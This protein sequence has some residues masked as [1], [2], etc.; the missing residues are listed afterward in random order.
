MSARWAAS[1]VRPFVAAAALGV[2]ALVLAA[3]ACTGGSPAALATAEQYGGMCPPMSKNLV[4]TTPPG[5]ACSA[6]E[7]CAPTCCD[8][9]KQ[10]KTFLAASCAGNACAKPADACADVLAVDTNQST[11]CG[12]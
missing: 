12:P 11:Y 1:A 10:T 3:G 2:L 5:G 4:G 8:G 9:P 7:E 6:A